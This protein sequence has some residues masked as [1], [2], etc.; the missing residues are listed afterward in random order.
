MEVV[1]KNLQKLAETRNIV[2]LQK[3]NHLHYYDKSFF[4]K[5]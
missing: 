2:I 1:R 4:G 3:V 5:D